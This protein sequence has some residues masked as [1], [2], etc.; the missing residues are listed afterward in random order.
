M[1]AL[2]GKVEFYR[3]PEDAGKYRSIIRSNLRQISDADGA[4]ILSLF[5]S[6]PKAK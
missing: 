2:E 5:K 1:K 4:L 6:L 3:G